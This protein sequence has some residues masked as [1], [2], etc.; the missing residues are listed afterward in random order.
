VKAMNKES[1]EFD[2]LMQKF[3]RISEAKIKEVIFVGPQAQQLFQDFDFEN[4][5]HA[6]YRRA[7]DA[8]ENVCG[9][10]WGNKIS[11]NYVEIMEKALLSTYRALG[12]SMSLKTP[13]PAIPLEFF[14]REI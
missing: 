12:C 10:F 13:F 5:L 11:E 6:V 9:N 7:W 1:K 14:S 4:K 3:P 8:C 2:Y